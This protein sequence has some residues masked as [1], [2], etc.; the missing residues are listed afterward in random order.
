MQATP[1]TQS[2]FNFGEVFLE[3]RNNTW[4]TPFLFNGK[5][6]DEET[7]LYYYGARYYDARI[8]L[9]LSTDPLQEKYPHVSTYAYTFN[10][11][12][13]Y[14]DPDG[15][16]GIRVI[17]TKN[18]TITIKALYFVQSADRN[19][20]TTKG[21]T[22]QFGG[23]SEKQ[24]GKMQESTNKYLNNLG[25][26]VSD[27][28]YKGYSI[29]FDLE[30]RDGG[31]VEQSENSAQS[32]M[33]DGHS[34][35]NSFTRGNSSVYSRFASKEIDN[36]DGTVSTSTVG[37]ITIGNKDIMMNSS[38]DTKMNRIHEIFHTFGFSHPKGT[39]GSEGIMK[40]PPEKP[41]QSDANQLGND[42]FL[43]A[44]KLE[45]EK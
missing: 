44:V 30:F 18:K 33:Q 22:K 13:I 31:T 11:P 2:S 27:G 6:L 14:K 4:N 43:P 37:G 19:Y 29:N 28:E 42:S 1:N 9:W 10:N 17:D 25:M 35:G 41:N 23:Y 26:S 32:E 7:G 15:R 16:D 39:G 38:Q 36:N 21:K 20:Y 12:V 24:I 3:E 34:V 5:E 8:S 45:D 40:Y